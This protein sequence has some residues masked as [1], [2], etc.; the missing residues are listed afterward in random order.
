MPVIGAGQYLA[1]AFVD[2]GAAEATWGA[3]RDYA[4]CT[5][6]LSEP[7]EFATLIRMKR[8]YSSEYGKD[9]ALR[10]APIERQEDFL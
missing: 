5:G 3:M 4:A 2:L 6:V 8:A 9:S 10:F 7:W 1:D